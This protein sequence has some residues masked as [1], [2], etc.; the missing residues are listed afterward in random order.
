MAL[1]AACLKKGRRVEETAQHEHHDCPEL[2]Q[3]VWRAIAKEWLH[4]TGEA[5]DVSNPLVTVMGMRGLPQEETEKREAA[6]RLLHGVVLLQ[7][8][9]ARNRVHTALHAKTP[10]EPKRVSAHH[11]LHEVRRRTQR[12]LDLIHLRARHA[13]ESGATHQNG[14][15]T[16]AEFQHHWITS[17]MATFSKHGPRLAL[18]RQRPSPPAPHPSACARGARCSR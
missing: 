16:M 2:A 15:S 17:G 14:R 1:C 18:F 4:V 5:L 10:Y 12:Q 6:W 11:V 13:V 9:R 7:L 3:K 8:H